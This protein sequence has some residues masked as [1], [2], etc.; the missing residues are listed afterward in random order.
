[1]KK[2]HIYLILTTLAI[3]TVLLVIAG[4]VFKKEE[5]EKQQGLTNQYDVSTQGTIAYVTHFKGKPQLKLY[6]PTLSV[7]EKVLELSNDEQILDPTYSYNGNMLAFIVA[8]KNQEEDSTSSI[9]LLDLKS[10]KISELF[11]AD[12]LITELD[13][14]KSGR[15]LFYIGA[16]SFK[17]YSPITGPRPHDLDIY[18]FD[19]EKKESTQ[20]TSFKKY[21]LSSLN[22]T[23]DGK[24]AYYQTDDDADA[25]TADEIFETHQRIFKVKFDQTGIETVTDSKRDVD[26]FDFTITPDEKTMI[27]QSISNEQSGSTYIYELYSYDLKTKTEK[28]LTHLQEYTDRPV[29][30]SDTKTVYFMVDKKFGKSDPQYHLYKVGIDGDNPEEILLPN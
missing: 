25:K 4:L 21:G 1:M 10:Q 7:E 15:S 5:N 29:I 20:L 19:I 9:Q 17:N 8:K 24:A 22:V 18:E 2:K 26:I 28:Q 16:G 6:N 30:S 12:F 27:F 13:F 23:T 11:K 14:T 3:V